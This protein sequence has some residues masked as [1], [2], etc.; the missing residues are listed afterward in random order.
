VEKF[1]EENNLLR[2]PRVGEIV[3]GKI[4]QKGKS[5]LLLDIGSFKPGVI[6]GKE[7]FAVK[8]VLK[9]FKI[10]DELFAKIIE[11]ENEEGY[12]ELSVQKAN[13]DLV[14]KELMEKKEKAEELRVKILGVN[15]GGLVTKISGL[16]AFLPL[17]QLSAEHLSE[18]K[19]LES[20]TIVKE[21][22]K[23]INKELK[24]KIFNLN[25]KN[26]TIILSEKI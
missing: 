14:W 18:R 19:E 12:V 7:F 22:Q 15:K 23:F 16:P 20:S 17:S 6:F 3:K 2:P 25:P 5:L 9:N 21:L 11:V 10:G 26:K 4:I 1:L 24:V 8:D 13:E